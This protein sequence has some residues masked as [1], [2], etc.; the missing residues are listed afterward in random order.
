MLSLSR[1]FSQVVLEGIVKE[2]GSGQPVQYASV[3]VLDA[4]ADTVCTGGITTEKGKF[5]ISNVFPGKYFLEIDFI[6]YRHIRGKTFTVNK[7]ERT[8]KDM[9]EFML[10]PVALELDAVD[11]S[12]AAPAIMSD[13]SKTVYSADQ[14]YSATG[15]T[16]CDVMK[17]IPSVDVAANGLVSLRGSPEVAILLNGKRAGILGGERRT[18]I[19]SVPV[20]ASMVDK[21]EVI[22]SPSAKQDADGMVGVINII[23]E[24]KP[25]IRIQWPCECQF[26]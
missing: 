19:M 7:E 4:D 18:N 5:H 20:P 15:G 11:I 24:R 2:S 16:C 22:T 26:R 14:I 9:G 10:E 8:V 17:G 1:L 3:A 21:V 13:V 12:A 6:G 23:F 25:G